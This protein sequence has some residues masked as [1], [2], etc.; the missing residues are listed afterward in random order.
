MARLPNLQLIPPFTD[1]TDDIY[2][3]LLTAR[4]QLLPLTD[5]SNYIGALWDWSM[6]AALRVSHFS[7][8]A[9]RTLVAALGVLTVL[10][11]YQLGRQW[12]G[13]LAGFL[14][15]AMLST[16]PLHILV[17][18]HVAWSNCVTPLFTTLGTWTIYAGVR[19]TAA[20]PHMAL[21]LSGLFWGLAFQTHP[22]AIALIAGSAVFLLYQGRT[23]MRT[24]WPYLA[25][26]LFVL[27]NL[28][29]LIYNLAS[30]FSSLAYGSR[31]IAAYG[32]EI[33]VQYSGEQGLSAQLYFE[34]LGRLLL[35]L[36][37]GLGGGIEV[38]PGQADFLSDASLWLSALLA[39]A[40]VVVQWRR[41]NPLPL[42]LL[43]ATLVVFPSF[44]GKYTV[45][46]NGRYLAPLLPVLY[47]ASGAL[48]AAG[49]RP[50]HA[51]HHSIGPRS[52]LP[53]RLGPIALAGLAAFVVL[54]PLLNLQAYYGQAPPNQTN[55]GLLQAIGQI[56]ANRR[57]GEVVVI[58]RPA[59][60]PQ[61]GTASGLPSKV[62]SLA[63][64]LEN[65][66]YR[67]VD[68]DSNELLSP[69]NRCRDQLVVVVPPARGRD[70]YIDEVAA[71]L[72]LRSLE[73]KPAPGEVDVRYP[74]Y[75]L[76]RL[77]DA[78]PGC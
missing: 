64:S 63:L 45:I 51:P 21:L 34:R 7:L 39:A 19:G 49:M 52:A 20:R 3:A 68:I 30:G 11:T 77:P 69:E 27:V 40:G 2:R 37:Q 47:A 6:A 13:R 23:L 61:I 1:E 32:K 16:S 44:N 38:R 42:L 46:L 75:R 59:A 73:P 24:R 5:T 9:P 60:E 26:G 33:A 56:E 66:P 65:A 41:G 18:S 31:V 43:T 62:F 50:L 70:L 17:N 76:D 53:A 74:V 78:P 36:S 4:G 8:Y 71:R 14:A 48:L 58:G 54:H 55:A 28:N 35:G 67:V 57:P 10:A 29:L 25:A 22:S 15:A 72:Q 12:G